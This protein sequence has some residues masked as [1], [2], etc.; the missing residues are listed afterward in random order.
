[1]ACN[2]AASACGD[3]SERARSS[4]ISMVLIGGF[5]F[6]VFETRLSSQAEMLIIANKRNN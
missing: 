4:K 5:G 6:E 2:N 1:M 3:G